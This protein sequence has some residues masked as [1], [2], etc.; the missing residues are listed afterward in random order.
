M[1]PDALH[2]ARSVRPEP[3]RSIA[4]PA[5]E[6]ILA[7][8]LPG[9]RVIDLQPL[10]DG[11]RNANFKLRLNGTPELVVLR[12]YEH[13]ASLC[14]KEID[15][16]RLVGGAVPVAEVIH[17]E[18]RGLDD[19]PPFM[20]MRYIEGITFLT[21]KRTG[22]AEAIAQA[23]HSAGESLA[24]IGRIRFPKPG[25]LGPGPAVTVPLM[26]GADAMPR[27]VDLCLASVDLQQRMPA[28]L[29]ERTHALMWT[30]ASQLDLLDNQTCLVHGD[31]S[32]RNL[33]VEHLGGRWKV[34]AV[35]DWEF[36]VSGPPLIDVANF[37]RY[38]RTSRPLAEP[39][40]SAGYLQA[41]G[42][43]PDDWRRLTRLVDLV[44]LCEMLTRDLLPD[45]VVTE[46][47]EIVRA[48]VE[49]SC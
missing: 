10:T 43:L 9:R 28:E 48:T 14:Q 46:L 16:M 49:K 44:A 20:L 38:E 22:D 18:P 7:S 29:R 5:L 8:A 24:A 30:F 15:L 31:F 25:W 33:L 32:R 47:V 45:A 23:A 3:R 39:H 11:L 36:A 1:A 41:G 17:A 2:P 6:R 13:D 4:A 12:L 19:I 35:L 40:F 37:L 34:T 21:L 27:F 42:K 26:E